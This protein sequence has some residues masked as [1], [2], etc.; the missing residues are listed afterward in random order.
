MF[1]RPSSEQRKGEKEVR[2]LFSSQPSLSLCS[3]QSS[4]RDTQLNFVS[5]NLVT[6]F[7]T[8]GLQN[9]VPSPTTTIWG[10]RSQN[11]DSILD[12]TV[13]V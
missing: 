5:K 1:T 7:P 4:P 2:F 3:S 13:F 10:A 9:G 8:K 11:G 6:P 12:R